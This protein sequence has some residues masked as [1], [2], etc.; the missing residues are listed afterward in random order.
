M[1]PRDCFTDRLGIA[2]IILIAFDVGLDELG[3]MSFTV[4]PNF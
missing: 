2:A 4:W 1:R 3:L